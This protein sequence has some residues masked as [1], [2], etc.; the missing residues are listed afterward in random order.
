[1]LPFSLS[2]RFSNE[3][4]KTPLVKTFSIMMLSKIFDYCLSKLIAKLSSRRHLSGFFGVVL[5]HSMSIV[6]FASI[7]GTFSF[8]GKCGFV[9][10]GIFQEQC[11]ALFN[12]EVLTIMPRGSSQIRILPQQI[13]YIALANKTTLKV[14]EGLQMY[15]NMVPWWKPWDK[16]PSWVK[17]SAGSD[18][19][20]SYQFTVG[21]VDKNFSPKIM[22]F[23]LTDPSKA[24][25]MVSELEF[26][27][28]L[29]IGETRNSSKGVGERLEHKIMKD[30]A[31]QSKR[32]SELCSQGM[33]EDAEPVAD[34]FN[35]YVN[36]T[37][38]EI[39]IFEGSAKVVS[40]MRALMSKTFKICDSAKTQEVAQAAAAERSRIIAMQRRY[41]AARALAAAR[42]DA[43]I[44][45]VK[46]ARR[47]AFDSL[48]SS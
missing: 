13:A 37:A 48:T 4:F 9:M 44:A 46:S 3:K 1:M 26:A 38:E 47:A 25:A 33:F 10:D 16:I 45:S 36:N 35:T 23:V 2:I 11:T 28:G 14:N 30:A 43:Y 8:N 17:E 34:A 15:N 41:A 29:S 24:S 6:P 39:G 31:K 12:D 22:L 7:A 42:A 20:E 32:I 40:K 19:A 18:K 5:F 21:Y 27:S